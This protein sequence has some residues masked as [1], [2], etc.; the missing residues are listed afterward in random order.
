[1][2][3]GVQSQRVIFSGYKCESNYSGIIMESVKNFSAEELSQFDGKNGKPAYVAFKGKVYDVTDSY[4]WIDGDH[5]GEHQ[6]GKDLTEQMMVAPHAEDVM[7]RMKV[8]G[9]LSTV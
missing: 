1:V 5:S 3:V 8:V 2:A 9:V 4:M 6:A 7:E